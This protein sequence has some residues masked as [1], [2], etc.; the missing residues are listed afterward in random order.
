M[1][2]PL[3]R[4][5]PAAFNKLTPATTDSYPTSLRRA[6]TLQLLEA[7]SVHGP[8]SS[9]NVS[10]YRFC[11]ILH[12]TCITRAAKK[13][14]KHL[15]RTAGVADI[16]SYECRHPSETPCIVNAGRKGEP[17]KPPDR[18][19]DC[20]FCL[21]RV[22][23]SVFLQWASGWMNPLM[24]PFDPY[25]FFDNSRS[26]RSWQCMPPSRLRS[27]HSLQCS[28]LYLDPHCNLCGAA[29]SGLFLASL[30]RILFVGHLVSHHRLATTSICRQVSTP[31]SR[32]AFR[33]P[34]CQ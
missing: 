3:T 4:Q 28:A 5:R 22:F 26:C 17:T 19:S 33:T 34:P 25:S 11:L 24:Q 27:T 12:H 30:G 7:V 2:Y 20:I 31:T 29:R 23:A 9:K 6:I 21:G 16:G 32:P 1:E 10:V 8:Q 15:S 14:P 13:Q 18:P